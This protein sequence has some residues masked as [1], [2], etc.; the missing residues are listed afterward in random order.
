MWANPDSKIHELIK[1]LLQN[2]AEN[3]RTWARHLTHISQMYGLEDPLI[4]LSKDPP[5][6]SVYKDSVLTKIIAFH[7]KEQRDKAKNIISMQYLNINLLGLRG[8]VHPILT[9]VYNS[10][11]VKK[12][13]PHIKMLCGDYMTFEKLSRQSGGS[14][15]C[16]MCLSGEDSTIEHLISRCVTFCDI[17]QQIIEQMSALLLEHPCYANINLHELKHKEL[18]QFIVDCSSMNLSKRISI[19]DPMLPAFYKLSR[20]FCYALDKIRTNKLKLI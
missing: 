10:H 6:K 14:P 12:M 16:R 9:N 1:Y 8:L 4:C 13:R 15:K 17:R 2:S 11:E 5:P 20:D 3:S 18:T 7:E 19:S